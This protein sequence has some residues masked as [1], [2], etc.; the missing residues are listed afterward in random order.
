[1]TV[2]VSDGAGQFRSATTYY[3]GPDPTGLTVANVGGI[4]NAD[5]LVG[6]ANG[7]VLVLVGNSDGTFR[8]YRRTDQ[9]EAL[10]VLP[11]SGPT[12]KFI[13]ADQ[14]LDRVVITDGSQSTELGNRSTGI[15]DPGA[16]QLADLS[17]NGIPDLGSMGDS[18]ATS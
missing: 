6:N 9:N 14:G 11:T 10:A 2:Y 5:L 8:P 1:V 3:A 12:P 18:G 13:F 15:L 17:G 4:G 7:D 16:V